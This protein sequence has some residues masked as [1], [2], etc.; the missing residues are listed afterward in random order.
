MLIFNQNVILFFFYLRCLWRHVYHTIVLNSLSIERIIFYSISIKIKSTIPSAM[1]SAF[2]KNVTFINDLKKGYEQIK[3]MYDIYIMVFSTERKFLANSLTNYSCCFNIW[4]M[5]IC[6]QQ[7]MLFGLFQKQFI[8]SRPSSYTCT[9]NTKHT[10][11]CWT[12]SHSVLSD[13]FLYT[14]CFCLSS[15]A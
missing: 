10:G 2:Y 9:V 3:Y 12:F 8:K 4:Y 14:I 11:F 15:P 7:N 13:F 6:I 1:M 5:Y